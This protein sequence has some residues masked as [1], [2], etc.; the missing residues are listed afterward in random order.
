MLPPELDC[1]LQRSSS[2]P[3]PQRA[4]LLTLLTML[5]LASCGYES[6]SSS[7]SPLAIV[8]SSLNNGQVGMPYTAALHAAGGTPPYVWSVVGGSLPIGLSLDPTGLVK[9]T[10]GA[11]ANHQSFELQLR[12]SGS[13]AQTATASLQLNIGPATISVTLSRANIGLTTNQQI[14]L[15][16]KTSDVAGLTWSIS[17]SGGS[18]SSV[19]S[20]SGSPVTFT[21]PA[22]AGIYTVTATSVTDGH[23]AASAAI[24]VTDL[25]GIYTYHNDL[26]RTGTNF[27]EYALTPANVNA[28][29][30]G[31][32]FSC[33]VDGAVYTQPLWVANLTVAGNKHNVVF[34][35][36]EHDSV[37]AFDADQTPCKQLWSA[38]LVD[39]AHGA[40]ADETAVLSA[41]P[42]PLVAGGG[43]IV[44]ETGITGTPVI[45][46][47]GGILYVV[48]KSVDATGTYFYQR[49]HALN[50]VTGTEQKGSPVTIAATY[51]GTGDGGSTVEFNPKSQLQRAGLALANSTVYISWASHGD[52]PP[53][54]GWIIG[55]TYDG[56]SFTQSAVLNVTPN[57]GYGGIWMSGAAP[58]VDA[59]GNIYVLTGNGTFD[60]DN[61][62]PLANNDY[63][64]SLL[65]LASN[66]SVTQYFSPSDQALG[67]SDDLDFGLS[68]PV[69][70]DLPAGAPVNHL[71]VGGGKDGIIRVFDRDSLGGY[72][73]QYMRQSFSVS[74]GIYPPASWS[75]NLFVSTA[76][77]LY[78]YQLDPTTALFSAATSTATMTGTHPAPP[79]ISA[80]KDASG[81]VWTIADAPN[82]FINSQV[83]QSGATATLV[84][85]DATN[86]GNEL[87]NSSVDANDAP[88][89]AVSFG[90]PTIANGK[91][92]IGTHGSGTGACSI[93]G[94]TG[95]L[96]VYGLK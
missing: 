65:Q 37:F 55:Y 84:A 6:P 76:A 45:D 19:T 50:L 3:M 14:S 90:V 49:L 72:G 2:R 86:L 38:S 94:N 60:A 80:A 32:L 77:F 85:F 51:P 11:V 78:A 75:N 82:C 63:G 39:S 1:G 20:L 9:G 33:T 12:D 36:T 67:M 92:Y 95:E 48:S 83:S 35:A 24:G 34:V 74:G 58:A 53:Y 7:S 62:G 93:A 27:Q 87:W 18:F 70:I 43:A 31:K 91:V 81:I 13:P 23:T 21:A 15:S 52:A 46:P 59:V 61:A 68:G 8:T 5:T 79:S 40:S 30:F 22:V 16:A 73:D 71:L 66:L 54:Y 29:T 25:T 64:D 44:P 26:A 96:A 10:P 17:P 89:Q 69:L 56:S 28:S 42:D 41:G 88:G 4:T 57:V 47:V